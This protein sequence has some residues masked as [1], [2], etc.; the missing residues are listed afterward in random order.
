MQPIRLFYVTLTPGHAANSA[1]RH[2]ADGQELP[3]PAALSIEQYPDDSGYYLM[4]LDSAGR[5]QT[6]TYHDTLEGAFEQAR[7]EFGVQRDKW[8]DWL[9]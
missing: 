6:D 9:N 5:E 4:Y 2:V 7:F 3:R 8:D 1:T